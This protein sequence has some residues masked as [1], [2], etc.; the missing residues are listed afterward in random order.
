LAAITGGLLIKM[1]EQ[2]KARPGSGG[3][4]QSANVQQTGGEWR[5]GN[6]AIDPRKTYKLAINDYLARGDEKG[7]DFLQAN[8]GFS[9]I[10]PGVG[11]TYDTRKLVIAQMRDN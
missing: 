2:G 5:V 1:L 3:F 9:I 4:L 11:E 8:A 7:F 10:D 6:T